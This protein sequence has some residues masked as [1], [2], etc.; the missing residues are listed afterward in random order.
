MVK[1]ILFI[2][3]FFLTTFF[4]FAQFPK[5]SVQSTL[6]KDKDFE[7]D[8]IH[9]EKDSLGQFYIYRIKNH[10]KR[11]VINY[12]KYDQN[13]NE[14]KST[15]TFIEKDKG[16][17]PVSI[18]N[19]NNKLYL[20]TSKVSK[21]KKELKLYSREIDQNNFS[22]T[23]SPKQLIN[24]SIY[25]SMRLTWERSIGYF[26]TDIS[27]DKKKLLVTYH[28][29]HE[30]GISRSFHFYCFNEHLNLKW[31]RNYRTELPTTSILMNSF[32]FHK[33][34]IYFTQIHYAKKEGR[35]IS[36]ITY[37]SKNNKLKETLIEASNKSITDAKIFID[38]NDN[39][40]C[41]GIYSNKNNEE[42]KLDGSF[43]I[44]INSKDNSI[45]PTIFSPIKILP[46][47]KEKKKHRDAKWINRFAVTDGVIKSDNS[48]TLLIQRMYHVYT[49]PSRNHSGTSY[50]HA[51]QI[52]AINQNSQGNATWEKKIVKLQKCAMNGSPQDFISFETIQIGDNICIF[53]NEHSR[54]KEIN[55]VEKLTEFQGKHPVITMV[56]IN[57][58]GLSKKSFIDLPEPGK[59][60]LSTFYS[61]PL[62][63]SAFIGILREGSKKYALGKIT[64]HQ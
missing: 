42:E 27:K 47:I 5:A 36:L 33:E 46:E 49:P 14:I 6:Y 52:I 13:L 59:P 41:A 21:K 54:N 19:I 55:S 3:L 8:N 62:N 23:D 17:T 45:N 18:E 48:L 51:N 44:R 64:I 28:S 58:S 61:F 31:E 24:K 11:I 2:M 40:I 34:N 25:K 9:F 10:R 26:S 4:S 22:I 38:Q 32:A 60:Y 16:E 20:L 15:E 37:S 56:M 1:H 35:K 57:K 29:P 12:E 63:Q 53:Y 39:I 43:S 50:I 30:D 7:F